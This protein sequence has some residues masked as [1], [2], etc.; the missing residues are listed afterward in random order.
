[1]KPYFIFY[2]Q[3]FTNR[4]REYKKHFKIFYPCKV[5]STSN[6]INL[7]KNEDCGFEV[8][9]IHMVEKLIKNYDV[10]PQKILYNGLIRSKKAIKRAVELGVRLFSI[11]TFESIKEFKPYQ[12]NS[13]SFLVRVSINSLMGADVNKFEKWGATIS[14][15]KE[16]ADYISKSEYYALEGFSFYFPKECKTM[17]RIS[18]ALCEVSKLASSYDNV[19]LD[20]G[21]G[22]SIDEARDIALQLPK[23]FNYIIEP[24]R[25][26]VGDC[27]DL[28][29]NIIDYKK[30]NGKT[31]VF[32]DVGIYS[33]FIDVIIKDHFFEIEALED[34]DCERIQCFVCGNTSDISDVLGQYNLPIKT[35]VSKSKVII[36]GCGAYCPQMH[37]PF[38]EHKIF[39]VYE[40]K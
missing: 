17:E 33:G 21:G 2:K 18:K 34:M 16:I 20:I 30:I 15:A 26:L 39:N 22:I 24:G 28:V 25:H 7:V 37:M 6:I 35:I 23:P 13:L 12:Q 3:K 10:N 29:C 4:L 9:S 14:Q 32:L 1:M 40:I 36:K 5:N 19:T 38:C 11:D 31:L 8:D 27:F